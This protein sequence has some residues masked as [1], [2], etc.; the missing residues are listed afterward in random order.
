LDFTGGL[1]FGIKGLGHG[2]SR[3]WVSGFRG[4]RVWGFGFGVKG[5]EFR[6]QGSGFR[7]QDLGCGRLG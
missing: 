1:K 4:L 2:G 3:F 6:V 7:V 5:L